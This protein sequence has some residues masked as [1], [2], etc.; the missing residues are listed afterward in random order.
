MKLS[1]EFLSIL[2]TG[3][4]C[5]L[6]TVNEAMD[7]ILLHY[8]CFPL[9]IQYAEKLINSTKLEVEQL[10]NS[11]IVDIV[12]KA[13]ISKWEREELLFCA[14]IEKSAKEADLKYDNWLASLE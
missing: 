8:N 13:I 14:G 3:H 7:N 9:E 6:E 1:K 4:I 10:L 2:E 12:P 5:G 11:R